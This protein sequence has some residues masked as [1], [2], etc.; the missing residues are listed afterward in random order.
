VRLGYALY[1]DALGYPSAGALIQALGMSSS[2]SI[3]PTAQLL[4][5]DAD[6]IYLLCS[7]GLSDYNRIE[8]YWQAEILPLLKGQADIQY[9]GQRLIDVANIANGH[10]NATIAIFHMQLKRLSNG[11]AIALPDLATFTTSNLAEKSS[12]Q[13]SN[14]NDNGAEVAAP[15]TQASSLSPRKQTNWLLL[16]LGLFGVGAIGFLSWKMWQRSIEPEPQVTAPPVE[17]KP[18]PEN[19]STPEITIP[20]ST[21]S[22]DQEPNPFTKNQI[23]RLRADAPLTA[24]ATPGAIAD[25]APTLWI[26]G[27][28]VVRIQEIN[29]ENQLLL[30]VCQLGSQVPPTTLSATVKK[31]TVGNR[32]WSSLK[33]VAAQQEPELE[34]TSKLEAL[35][36]GKATSGTTNGTINNNATTDSTTTTKP[37]APGN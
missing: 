22:A 25:A 8:Q 14:S 17:P 31:I 23:L 30:E 26:P 35:C 34:I 5:P 19:P 21:N 4:T 1:Q 13:T 3:H 33:N 29:P 15:V 10:D 36:T 9:V 28:T 6:C 20:D 27:G 2:Q 32:G 18:L 37:P 16:L 12:N 7:D 24:F 11:A